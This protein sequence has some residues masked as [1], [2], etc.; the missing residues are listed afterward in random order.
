[1]LYTMYVLLRDCC[2][3]GLFYPVYGRSL[4]RSCRGEGAITT[5]AST[6]TTDLALLWGSLG[7]RVAV[8]ADEGGGNLNRSPHDRGKYQC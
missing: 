7:K 6:V 8:D 4:A 5:S 1:M 2:L 3:E